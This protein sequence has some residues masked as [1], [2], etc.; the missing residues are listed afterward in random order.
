MNSYKRNFSRS[1]NFEEG[2]DF[3]AIASLKVQ[4]VLF[5]LFVLYRREE[6][7]EALAESKEELEHN[8]QVVSKLRTEVCFLEEARANHDFETY[9]ITR[10]ICVG[11]R[12]DSR[13]KIGQA[14]SRRTRCGPRK[15]G[16]S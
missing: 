3:R 15:G 10:A 16:T 14:V 7:S 4:S 6:K 8:K 12:A 5:M 13:G 9:T 11:S 1:F 2:D